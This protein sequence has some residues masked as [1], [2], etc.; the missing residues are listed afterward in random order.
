[1]APKIVSHSGIPAFDCLTFSGMW[2]QKISNF[3]GESFKERI[4][5]RVDNIN[6]LESEPEMKNQNKI[7]VIKI[8]ISD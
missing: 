4:K 8:N 6:S 2:R 7:Y 1:M 3:D 5:Q